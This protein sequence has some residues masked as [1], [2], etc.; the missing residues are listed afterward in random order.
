MRI[1]GNILW[2]IPFLGFVFAFFYC[3]WG[4]LLCCTVILLPLGLG[5]FQMAKFMLAPFTHRMVPKKDLVW[6]GRQESGVAM[7]TFSLVIRIVYFPFGLIASVSAIFLIVAE[8]ITILG[9]PSALVWA[10]LLSSIFNP[11]NKVCVSVEEANLIARRKVEACAGMNADPTMCSELIAENTSEGSSDISFK[12]LK[13]APF[14]FKMPIIGAIICAFFG[15]IGNLFAAVGCVIIAKKEPAYR[16]TFTLFAIVLIG[17]S[18]TPLLGWFF[19]ENLAY[20]LMS[21]F[22]LLAIVGSLNLLRTES[23]IQKYGAL[24]MIVWSIVSL[25]VQIQSLKLVFWMKNYVADM[26]NNSF[27]IAMAQNAPTMSILKSI[28]FAVSMGLGFYLVVAS[29]LEQKEG[30]TRITQPQTPDQK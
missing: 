17:L 3:L 27:L 6:L 14:Y 11:V 10:K 12:N 20:I 4:L 2:H 28:L 29:I 18:C 21:V 30:F 13:K 24:S 22:P 8:F 1:L 9:I 7:K 26:V 19:P 25:F 23:S 16:L 15:F 5:Y